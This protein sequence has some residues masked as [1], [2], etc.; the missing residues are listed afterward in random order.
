MASNASHFV[1]AGKNGLARYVRQLKRLTLQFCSQ[2]GSSRGLREY[3]DGEITR[4][5]RN[6]PQVAVYVRERRRRHPRL[7]GEFLNGNS[8]VVSVKNFTSS[9]VAKHV[10]T[11]TNM[12]GAKPAKLNKRWHTDNPT[13]QGNWTPFMH[14]KHLQKPSLQSRKTNNF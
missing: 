13:I 5:A 14:K 12:S 11:L 4:F 1:G 3:I 8:R 6:T 9:E 7:I 10:K 2:G